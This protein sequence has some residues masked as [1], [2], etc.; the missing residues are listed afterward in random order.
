M[1]NGC[2]GSITPAVFTVDLDA[3]RPIVRPV[4]G[5]ARRGRCPRPGF[6]IR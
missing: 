4:D 2:G 1:S 3:S 5:G 6:P